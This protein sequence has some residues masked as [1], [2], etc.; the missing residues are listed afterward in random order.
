MTNPVTSGYG[1]GSTYT[2]ASAATRGPGGAMGKDEFLQLLVAQLKNQDP[3]N[4]ADGQ[5]FAAQ[6]A[7]FS[8]VEQLMSINETLAGQ[9][10]SSG[11]LLGAMN[12]N[13]ALS[14]IGRTVVAAGD[15]LVATEAQPAEATFD[16]G[17]G[18][19]NA[20]LTVKDASGNVVATRELGH[21]AEGRHTVAFTGGDA[22]QPGEYNYS[23]SVKD[24]DGNAVSVQTYTTA[25]ISGVSTDASGVTLTSGTLAIP[26]GSIIEVRAD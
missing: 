23:V 12:A 21:V 8:S 25:R 7:Q 14:T 11:A 2:S 15:F 18:G 3:L 26:F 16:V 1:A 20:V 6:L 4:P 24:A 9:S 17:T 19:G 13:A 22:L 10:G 5:E